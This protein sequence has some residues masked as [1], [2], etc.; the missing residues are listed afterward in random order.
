MTGARR[1]RKRHKHNRPRAA[2]ARA[3]PAVHEVPWPFRPAIVVD[4]GLASHI[5]QAGRVLPGS[6]VQNTS[7]QTTS[8]H[9]MVLRQRVLVAPNAIA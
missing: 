1:S 3:D 4:N 8:L 6:V 2:A 5:S 9:S 7:K